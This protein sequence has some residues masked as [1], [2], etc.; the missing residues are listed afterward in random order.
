MSSIYTTI[1]TE[2]QTSSTSLKRIK[3]NSQNSGPCRQIRRDVSP[4]RELIAQTLMT[5][6]AKL[7]GTPT[8]VSADAAAFSSL[9]SVSREWRSLC[10]AV[11]L[12]WDMEGTSLMVGSC[13]QHWQSHG[14]GGGGG[15]CLMLLL[16]KETVG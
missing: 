8:T 14:G 15:V 16:V 13:L 2:N 5:W 3:R 11:W 6:L 7:W 10:K 12:G 9:W 4:G 1:A